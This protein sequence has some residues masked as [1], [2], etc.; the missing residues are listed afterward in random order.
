MSKQHFVVIACAALEHEIAT[1]RLQ[2]ESESERVVSDLCF[3]I[4]AGDVLRDEG[5][6][7][8]R[9]R[10]VV[11]SS[12]DE[13]DDDRLWK[14][15]QQKEEKR[16]QSREQREASKSSVRVREG[17]SLLLLLSACRLVCSYRLPCCCAV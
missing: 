16:E 11:E 4:E 14:Q 3:Q 1:E 2:C 8:A 5:G 13:D 17:R 15:E 12:H 9:S 6:C 7:T 10:C